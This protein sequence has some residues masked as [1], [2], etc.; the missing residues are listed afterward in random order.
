MLFEDLRIDR[1]V[2]LSLDKELLTKLIS[3]YK[4]KNLNLFMKLIS[5]EMTNK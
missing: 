4:S 2:F 3:K 1:E 5:R